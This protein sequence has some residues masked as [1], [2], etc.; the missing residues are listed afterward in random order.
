MRLAE[1]ASREPAQALAR[2]NP[3]AGQQLSEPR[4]R[5]ARLDVVHE[6]GREEDAMRSTRARARGFHELQ[7]AVGAR[8]VQLPEQVAESRGAESARQIHRV[9]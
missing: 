4:R 9:R 7:N 3:L 5:Q 8:T 1:Q 6:T 2:Q